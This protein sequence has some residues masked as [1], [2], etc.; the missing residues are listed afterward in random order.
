MSYR[1]NIYQVIYLQTSPFSTIILH[2]LNLSQTYKLIFGQSHKLESKSYKYISSLNQ[3]VFRYIRSP[4]P[5]RKQN[6]I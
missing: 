4:K 2:M 3:I 1:K 5:F 6:L